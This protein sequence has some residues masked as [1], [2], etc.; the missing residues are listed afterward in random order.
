[1]ESYLE[2]SATRYGRI[3]STQSPDTVA[4]GWERYAQGWD[5]TQHTCD[6]R[7]INVCRQITAEISEMARK[8]QIFVYCSTKY[9][10]MSIRC[11]EYPAYPSYGLMFRRLII[12]RLTKCH[13]TSCHRGFRENGA[14]LS[15]VCHKLP[16]LVH[17]QLVES[18]EMQD[19]KTPE[20]TARALLRF[21]AFLVLNHPKLDMLTWPT[22]SGTTWELDGAEVTPYM[23]LSSTAQ[24][25]TVHLL[26][27]PSSRASTA[28]DAKT[29]DSTV[30]EVSTA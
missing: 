22:S 26:G 10:D 18:T 6:F 4:I 27:E 11:S 15:L 8:R 21:G 1:M 16:N 19:G 5:P 20:E 7:Y 3:S 30:I 9:I 14:L 12:L 29:G 2:K 25:G 23:D 28:G 13:P 17:F 24:Y